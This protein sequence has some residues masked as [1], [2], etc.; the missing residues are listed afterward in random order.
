MSILDLYQQGVI[1][2]LFNK[3]LLSGSTLAY[4]EYYKRFMQEK[5]EGKRYRESV[6]KL[7]LEFGVSETT[8]KKAIRVI[9]EKE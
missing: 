5:A 9:N 4:V 2:Y 1:G 7:S 8:I 6:R 3:G